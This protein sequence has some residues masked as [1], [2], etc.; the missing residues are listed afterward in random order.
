MRGV[1]ASL[2]TAGLA[3]G[4][5]FTTSAQAGPEDFSTGPL[6]ADYGPN[7]EIE[8]TI[9][10]PPDTVFRPLYDVAEPAD[11][12]ELNRSFVT[13]ARFLNMHARAGVPAENMHLAIVIHG[14]AIFDVAN[15]E[16]FERRHGA[17]AENANAALIAE[18]AEHG[19]TFYV[20]GQSAAHYDLETSEL[21]PGVEMALSAM[22]V[23][24]VLQQSG[25]T[26]NPF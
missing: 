9:A 1:L 23:H 21:L 22:T 19:V 24:A 16:A 3:A 13:A 15:A 8:T 2:L 14:R 11:P 20:C 10:F 26:L 4:G 6:I 5:V 17:G 12:G 7:A 25:Y 18:L